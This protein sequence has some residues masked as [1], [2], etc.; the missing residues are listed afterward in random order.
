MI[1]SIRTIIFL[2]IAIF[3][4][5]PAELSANESQRDAS[6]IRAAIVY[7]IAKYVTWPTTGKNSNSNFIIGILANNSTVQ[8]WRNLNGKTIYGR[9]VEVRRIVD[10]EELSQCQLIFIDTSEKKNLTRILAIASDYPVLTISEIEDFSRYGGMIALSVINNH[11][12]FS[13]NLKR[14]R[15]VNLALSSNILK[16]ATE[17]IK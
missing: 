5:Y 13:I 15:S 8:S 1:S 3:S 11:M 10:L 17:V 4:A 16:L 14:A 9:T 2:L 7:N 6:L 12:A